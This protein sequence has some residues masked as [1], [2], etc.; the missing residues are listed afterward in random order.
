MMCRNFQDLHPL[1][2]VVVKKERR[3]PQCPRCGMQADPQYPAHIN[4]K[5]CRAGTS[6]LNQQD[7][8]VRLALHCTSSSQCIGACWTKLGCF[9][10]S[11]A[12]SHRMM[13][14]SKLCEASFTRHAECGHR[15]DRC[16]GRRMC[17]HK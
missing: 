16:C 7:M 15:S 1:D 3:Y 17:P 5:E 10:T 11:A 2:F 12:C 13:M 8:A 4:T 9:I 14:S 6:Q